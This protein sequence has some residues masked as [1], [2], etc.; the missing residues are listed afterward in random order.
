MKKVLLAG[1]VALLVITGCG[2]KSSQP[3]APQK[4]AE[5]AKAPEPAKE[6]AVKAP[7]QPQAATQESKEA[8]LARHMKCREEKGADCFQI[9]EEMKGQTTQGQAPQAQAPQAQAPQQQLADNKAHNDAV[10]ARHM[11]CRQENGKDCLK[12]LEEI[13]K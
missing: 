6:E 13:R 12:I 10:M 4:A 5:P 2:D 1:L 9:L 7:D 3:T 8:L 11:K